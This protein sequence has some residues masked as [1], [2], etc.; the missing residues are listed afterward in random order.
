MSRHWK[1]PLDPNRH[2]DFMGDW[3]VRG[4][5]VDPPR[6]NLLRPWVYFVEVCSF[7]FQF[8]S[9]EQIDECLTHFRAGKRP[10]DRRPGHERE[11][12]WQPWHQRLPQYL[13]K[14]SRRGKVVRALEQALSHFRER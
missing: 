14:A 7:T 12:Y 3:S 4:R 1:E 9:L 5:P 11:H 8:Q 2:T 13:F 6:D 10:S